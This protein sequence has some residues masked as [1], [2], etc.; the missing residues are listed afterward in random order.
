MPQYKIILNFLFHCL[1]YK[2]RLKAN[3]QYLIILKKIH[4]Y[5]H[6]VTYII[7]A[8]IGGQK[9]LNLLPQRKIDI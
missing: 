2:S 7:Y 5:I 6:T 8:Q 1:I 3:F 9:L 4:I